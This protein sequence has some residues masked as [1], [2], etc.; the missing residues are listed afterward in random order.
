[1]SYAARL[2]RV[3]RVPLYRSSF[4]LMLT[5]GLNGLLG[6][7]YWVFWRLVCTRPRP[8]GSAPARSAL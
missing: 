6:F 1:M 3:R 8:S 5:T 2:N 7:A 4:A